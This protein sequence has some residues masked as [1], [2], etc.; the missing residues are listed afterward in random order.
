MSMNFTTLANTEQN[1]KNH[2]RLYSPYEIKAKCKE[3][4]RD[5]GF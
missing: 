1:I 3:L 2:S 5:P 4:F